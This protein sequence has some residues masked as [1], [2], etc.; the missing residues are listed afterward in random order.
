M[1]GRRS[2]R[3]GSSESST[4]PDST[5]TN[6]ESNSASAPEKRTLT[7][8]RRITALVT[9]LL[10]VIGSSVVWFATGGID[11][12]RA[13]TL[14]SLKEAGRAGAWQSIEPE[15]IPLPE[16]TTPTA[17]GD[18]S[19][20]GEIA[21]AQPARSFVVQVTATAGTSDTAISLGTDPQGAAPLM[22]LTAGTTASV[23]T[24]VYL[25]SDDGQSAPSLFTTADAALSAD[26]LAY[27]IPAQGEA[28]PAPGGTRAIT[29]FNLVDLERE[30]GVT[31]EAAQKG[32]DLSPLGLG[33][34]PTDGAAGVWLQIEGNGGGVDVGPTDGSQQEGAGSNHQNLGLTAVALDSAGRFRLQIT[35]DVTH[36][37]ISIVG[38]IARAEQDTDRAV[39]DAGIFLGTPVVQELS[40]G[41]PDAPEWV[42]P[43]RASL[44]RV[45]LNAPTRSQ[46]GEFSG[47]VDAGPT[48]AEVTGESS[49]VVV[50]SEDSTLLH[51]S[52]G[53][54]ATWLGYFAGPTDGED[55]PEVEIESPTAG[56]DIDFTEVGG[57]VHFEG[58]V[59]SSSGVAGVHIKK[60]NRYVGSARVWLTADGYRWE[61]LTDAPTG[62]HTVSVVALDPDG[63]EGSASVDFSISE[64]ESNAFVA[65]PNVA[66]IGE[67]LAPT[68]VASDPDSLTFS[69]ATFVAPGDVVSVPITEVTPEG[70]LRKVTS[71][72][73]VDG[74]YVLRTQPAV[75]TD[76]VVNAHIVV[77]DAP[78]VHVETA[79]GTSDSGYAHTM[80]VPDEFERARE[81]A[82]GSHG[83]DGSEGSQGSEAAAAIDL[84]PQSEDPSAD[85]ANISQGSLLG[86]LSAGSGG[87]FGLS[88]VVDMAPVPIPPMD[89]DK[90]KPS[91]STQVKFHVQASGEESDPPKKAKVEVESGI[92]N[93]SPNV[94]VEFETDLN[95]KALEQAS[96][97]S[98]THSSN[99]KA[100]NTSRW[101]IDFTHT[102]KLHSY[103]KMELKITRNDTWLNAWGFSNLEILEISELQVE[104]TADELTF[105]GG[106]KGSFGLQT[107]DPRKWDTANDLGLDLEAMS[108]TDDLRV[109]LGDTVIPT[110]VPIYLSFYMKP[111]LGAEVT[112]K[113]AVT[114]T[115]TATEVRTEG[116]RYEN[117]RFSKVGDHRFA[118]HPEFQ[119]NTAVEVGLTIKLG[120][121]LEVK[122]YEAVGTFIGLHGKVVATA[123]ADF[124]AAGTNMKAELSFGLDAI[125]GMRLEVFSHEIA[126]KKIAFRLVDPKPPIFKK[127]LEFNLDGTALMNDESQKASEVSD[128]DRPLVLIIDV[129]GSMSGD[130]IA[131]AKNTLQQVISQQPEGSE[132]GI[133]TYPSDGGCSPGEFIVPLQAHASIGELQGTIAGL[134]TD[135]S[136]PTGEALQAAAYQMIGEGRTGGSLLLVSDG[137]SNCSVDPC[138]TVADI[139]EQG[140]ELAVN[141]VGFDISEEGMKQLQ[142]IADATDSKAYEV[143]N[144][145]DL[146]P[147]IEDL[148]Q[149]A[150][151]ANIIAPEVVAESETQKV[152]V[153]IENPSVRDATAVE[154]VLK[155]S[156][157]GNPMVGRPNNIVGNI[158]P[159]GSIERVIEVHSSGTGDMEL[160][161]QAWG[162]NVSAVSAST[163]YKVVDS[164]ATELQ[165]TPGPIL[166]RSG[167]GAPDTAA[168]SSGGSAGSAP[169]TLLIMGDS[170]AAGGW[171]A[172]GWRA[173]EDVSSGDFAGDSSLQRQVDSM[174]VQ[175]KQ[176]SDVVLGAGGAEM[177]VEQVLLTCIEAECTADSADYQNALRIAQ[178]IRFDDEILRTWFA[179][180]SDGDTARSGAQAAPIFVPAYPRLFPQD[181]GLRCSE[182]IGPEQ[183]TALNTLVSFLNASLETSVQ[184]MRNAG[185]EVYFVESTATAFEDSNSLCSE[186]PGIN[187]TEDP[188]TGQQAISLTE[189]GETRMGQIVLQWSQ[190]RDREV[191]DAVTV[192][193][194]VADSGFFTRLTTLPAPELML[195]VDAPAQSLGVDMSATNLHSRRGLRDVT[196]LTVVPGQSLRVTGDGYL[197]GS[198]VFV[199]LDADDLMLL[200]SAVAGED[201]EAQVEV[202]VPR[203][204]VPGQG[205]IVTLATNQDG[206]SFRALSDV[207]IGAKAPLWVSA[208]LALSG[209]IGVVGVALV[210]VRMFKRSS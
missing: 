167:V 71:A 62:E 156:G 72:Q 169:S 1:R 110:P 16:T 49:A 131:G 43:G 155:A 30:L 28:S 8:V 170:I 36:L 171:E 34:V 79:A 33:G 99:I 163:T 175:A 198:H 181:R 115:R 136:T 14:G 128:G 48:Q 15:R 191:S 151:T 53:T 203:T 113:G 80:D 124:T 83:T 13:G 200:G 133:W 65:A 59:R 183:T 127:T 22:Q 197:P 135:G 179:V 196:G 5:P 174:D 44:Y 37:H 123:R 54:Q 10:L 165:L 81:E 27:F 166:A 51:E 35:P 88:R 118:R 73:I 162:T 209:I 141:T 91:N 205:T 187:I 84:S 116:T 93:A 78:V 31:S 96:E 134:T 104:E 188:D 82:E 157:T 185:L 77:N 129:S 138:D 154:F 100:K 168:G 122:G 107:K 119:L 137:E 21:A 160:E 202:T 25:P 11:I 207:V 55:I 144:P 195:E 67:D 39:I 94:T 111:E 47:V 4:S 63:R 114:A 145:D 143:E 199:S 95:L 180:N 109:R 120:L 132:I 172:V 89:Y 56:Q 69:S 18:L 42:P 57:A 52:G 206:E 159:N 74:Q 24:L 66:V 184:R 29:P 105:E 20:L 68:L 98:K 148:T 177:D 12:A 178:E 102:T 189:S 150:I 103:V 70:A 50:L 112:V 173:V 126:K 2:S 23:T 64:V 190:G 139:R 106:Y 19:A 164:G 87:A 90:T 142:C 61:Y 121:D 182:D 204:V 46:L 38:W 192:A 140:F 26:V 3:G 161:V 186:D 176:I 6:R 149:T 92:V 45:E 210:G 153:R 101:S 41:T 201:G 85:P 32:M 17:P 76:A 60:G 97:S 58:T 130:R 125:V 208:I 194:P 108:A 158:P 146:M 86:P 152:T 75:L 147:L 40:D 9:T 117:G 7:R 193:K